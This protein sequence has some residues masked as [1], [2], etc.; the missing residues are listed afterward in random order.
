VAFGFVCSLVFSIVAFL[1]ENPMHFLN[2]YKLFIPGRKGNI[3]EMAREF[4]GVARSWL[5]A[6]REALRFKRAG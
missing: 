6:L 5:A 1:D 3:V 2:L 4:G